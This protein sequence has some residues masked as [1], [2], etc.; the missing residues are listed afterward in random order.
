MKLTSGEYVSARFVARDDGVH[1][2][3]ET[4]EEARPVALA[5]VVTIGIP[6]GARWSADVKAVLN[7]SQGNTETLAFGAAAEAFRETDADRL[8]FGGLL[9]RESKDER[10]HRQEHARLGQL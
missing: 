5:D 9:A 2:E 10:G 8:R 4:V 6:P 3:S 7:G 1:L